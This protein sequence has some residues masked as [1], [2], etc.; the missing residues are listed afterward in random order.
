MLCSEVGRDRTTNNTETKVGTR[1][2]YF[3]PLSVSKATMERQEEHMLFCR[4]A[5]NAHYVSHPCLIA[6]YPKHY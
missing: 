4:L 3:R 2:G 5:G 1:S 6:R